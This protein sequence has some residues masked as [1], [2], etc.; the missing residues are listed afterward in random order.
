MMLRLGECGRG[1]SAQKHAAVVQR[2]TQLSVHRDARAGQVISLV[3]KRFV[4]V[5]ECE[6]AKT[7]M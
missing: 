4:P 1:L 5:Y 3:H 2:Q 7:S 6:S